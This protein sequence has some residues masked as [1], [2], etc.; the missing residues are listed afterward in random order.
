[1]ATLA[2]WMVPTPFERVRHVVMWLCRIHLRRRCPTKVRPVKAKPIWRQ[3]IAVYW[4]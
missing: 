4:G 3:T 2:P 1:M